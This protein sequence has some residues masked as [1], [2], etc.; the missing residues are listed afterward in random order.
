MEFFTSQAFKLFKM[1]LFPD[2]LKA[3]VEIV[4]STP[5]NPHSLDQANFLISLEQSPFIR[6]V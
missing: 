3:G 1:Q 6:S 2:G 5:V 4:E